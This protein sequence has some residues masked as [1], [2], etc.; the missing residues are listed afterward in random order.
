MTDWETLNDRQKKVL[1]AA[2]DLVN[3]AQDLEEVLHCY[4][5]IAK[6][7]INSTYNEPNELNEV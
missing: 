4:S 3:G 2:L 1:W 6:Y 5:I 7:V